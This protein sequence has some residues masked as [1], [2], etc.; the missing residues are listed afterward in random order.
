ML[1]AHVADSSVDLTVT[2]PPY[3][4]LRLYKGHGWSFKALLPE[5]WRVTKPGGVVMW[6]VADQVVNGSETGTSFRQA[7][8]FMDAGWRLHDTMFYEKGNF[9]NP[10]SNRYH[11][12]AEYMFVFSKGKP[13]TFNP[14]KDKPNTGMNSPDHARLSTFGK[15]TVRNHDGTMKERGTRQQY[16]EFG[17][18]G[19]IWRMK[20]AGQ[21]KPCQ[22][23]A[24][25]AKMPTAMAHDHIVSWSNPGDMILDPFAG[26]GTTGV[27]ALKLGRKFVGIEIA[28]EYFDI[29]DQELKNWVSFNQLIAP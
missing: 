14:I 28:A 6:N 17:M 27:E 20:T 25:P 16:A 12:L 15:N 5:L 18:R 23:V 7:L 11:Q 26:S 8:A 19:N 3:D 2:S 24:H 22:A 21:E 1:Q 13:K 29:M 4:N 10:S 9:S